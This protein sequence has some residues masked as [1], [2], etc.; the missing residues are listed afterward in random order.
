MHAVPLPFFHG[1][2]GD[3]VL[4][5]QKLS[6]F[7]VPGSK[8][9]HCF[10]TTPLEEKYLRLFVA[11]KTKVCMLM[12]KHKSESLPKNL[13]EMKIAEEFQM[14]RVGVGDACVCVCVRACVHA[15]VHAC[16]HLWIDACVHTSALPYIQEAT[17]SDV[18]VMMTMKEE[19][20][21]GKLYVAYKNGTIDVLDEISAEAR[22][23]LTVDSRVS[24]GCAAVGEA[25]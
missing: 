25:H 17:L 19:I 8:G 5:K 23:F 24:G 22:R 11:I 21:S 4:D 15:W 12:W 7:R 3:K 6:A 16:V 20:P 2:H 9:T 10:C 13:A 1:R 14:H 18:P